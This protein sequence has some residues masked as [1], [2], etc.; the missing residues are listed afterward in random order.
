MNSEAKTG[1]VLSFQTYTGAMAEKEDD[2]TQSLGHRVVMDLMQPFLGKGHHVYVDNYYTLIPPF[3]DL[4]HHGTYVTGTIVSNR[5]DFPEELKEEKNKL[6]IGSY[7][8]ATTRQLTACIWRDRRDVTMLSMIHNT[9]V[10]IVMKR[11]KGQKEKRPLP[12]PSCIADYNLNMNRV[13]LMDQQL[14]YYSLTRQRTI[15]WWKKVFWRLVDVAI[16]KSWIIFGANNPRSPIDTQMKFRIELCRQLVQ[17][18]QQ[19]IEQPQHSKG[20]TPRQ[21]IE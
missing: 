9:S 3:L 2:P 21:R 13:D 10:T 20:E 16:V 5:R 19:G 7:K 12:C 1:Y 11:P 14:S 18:L 17:P 4:L 6:P 15:N 8:F